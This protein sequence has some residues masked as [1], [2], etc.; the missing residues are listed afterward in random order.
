MGFVE[1]RAVVVSVWAAIHPGAPAIRDAAPIAD[2]IAT[3][4]AEDVARGLPV[5]ASL[6]AATMAVYAWRE[7][8]LQARVVGDN[9]GSC[10]PWQMHCE[11]VRAHRMTLTDQARTWLRWT[12]ES[13]LAGVD[14]SPRRAAR[15]VAYAR[16]LLER[17][18]QDEFYP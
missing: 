14:S 9:G 13:S 2:A 12:R 17:I 10:G 11:I 4:V 15:R 3:A 18:S 6:E 8:S 1:L 5:D 16:R 7:S